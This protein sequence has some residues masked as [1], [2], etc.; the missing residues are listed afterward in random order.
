MII[1]F[2]ILTCISACPTSIN[3]SDDTNKMSLYVSVVTFLHCL[4]I[5]LIEPAVCICISPDNLFKISCKWMERDF[6]F[7]SGSFK[8]ENCLYRAPVNIASHRGL[9]M[10]AIITGWGEQQLR[11]RGC[12]WRCLCHSVQACL[13]TLSLSDYYTIHC[14]A[15]EWWTTKVRFN[16]N[17]LSRKTGT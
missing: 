11:E 10:T 17:E 8:P 9:L 13:D 5:Q 3:A 12:M 16:H 2:F 1:V 15:Q 6:A 14:K 7:V 4:L